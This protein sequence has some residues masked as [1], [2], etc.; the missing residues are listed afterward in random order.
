MSLYF[1][2]STVSIKVSTLVQGAVVIQNLTEYQTMLERIDGL[3]PHIKLN[4]IMTIMI[5]DEIEKI[6]YVYKFEY[7]ESAKR[8]PMSWMLHNIIFSITC[9]EKKNISNRTF[10][11]RKKGFEKLTYLLK[12]EYHKTPTSN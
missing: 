7:L 11:Y 9:L 3:C 6:V 8:T 2:G 4:C 10:Y 12:S 1:I 5:Y